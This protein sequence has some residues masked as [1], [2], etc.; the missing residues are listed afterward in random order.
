MKNAESLVFYGNRQEPAAPHHE[1]HRQPEPYAAAAGLIQAV[2]LAMFVGRP[3]LLEGEA[4]CGKTRLARAVAYE[5]GLPLHTW[6]VRSTSKAL[7]GLY[8]Y[9]AI[10]RLHDVQIRQLEARGGNESGQSPI[11]RD[12]GNPMDYRELGPLGKAFALR[13][14]PAVVLIDEIDKADIDFPN[15]LLA[16]LDDPW[17]FEIQETGEKIKAKHKPIV[18]I[19]SNKEKGNL[20]FPF[21]RRCIYYYVEFPSEPTLK[22]IVEEHYRNREGQPS[23]E[24]IQSAARR[25]VGVRN[26]GNLHKTPSTSEFLD[27]VE[28]LNSFGQD[29]SDGLQEDTLPYPSLLFKLRPDWYRYCKIS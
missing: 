1:S 16:V 19:T 18:I 29:G 5:L 24:L 14:C 28:A 4:G 11:L 9:D 6:H 8:S 26:E 22:K 27:W 12:P 23:S 17:E 13:D 7:E 2:N 25:F 15:D 21:L 20:P 3:L 10:L